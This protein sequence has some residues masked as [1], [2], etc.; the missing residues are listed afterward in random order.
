MSTLQPSSPL[1]LNP[2]Q[3]TQSSYSAY[4]NIVKA[5]KEAVADQNPDNIRNARIVGYTILNAPDP[6]A[7]VSEALANNTPS[8]IYIL[9]EKYLNFFIKPFK[10]NRGSA[11]PQPSE[12]ST[13]LYEIQLRAEEAFPC[14]DHKSAKRYA[15]LR[16]QFKCVLTGR[17]DKWETNKSPGLT[18]KA[19][20]EGARALTTNCA[21]IFPVSISHSKPS[22]VDHSAAVWRVLKMVG[23][24]DDDLVA[25]LSG[26]GI[27]QLG[28]VLT[29]ALQL[30][31]FFDTLDLWLER[32]EVTTNEYRVCYPTTGILDLDYLPKIVTLQA[33]T[34][35]SLPRSELLAVH[36]AACRVAHLSGAAEY[37]E[38]KEG[39][40]EDEPFARLSESD[41]AFK[42]DRR[43]QSIP[44][45]RSVEDFHKSNYS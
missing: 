43:L 16:D 5:E 34:N 27:N 3:R 8:S 6:Q 24:L 11:I 9:G 7:I 44:D 4:E 42:L 14:T 35:F 18:A 45:T 2:F 33:P 19:R 22:Q 28:N 10:K 20:E 25:S 13:P 12:I 17:Y 36:A 1:P 30:H 15:L 38:I 31:D 23:G 41:F 32:V 39:E 37:L 40:D 21:H 26:S 29:L